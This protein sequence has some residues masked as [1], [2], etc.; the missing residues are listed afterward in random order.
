[1]SMLCATN[2]IEVFAMFCFGFMFYIIAADSNWYN[3]NSSVK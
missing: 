1:M 3:I 2:T